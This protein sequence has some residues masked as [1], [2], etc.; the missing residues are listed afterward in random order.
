MH[1]IKIK[2]PPICTTKV[3]PFKLSNGFLLNS[4]TMC[5]YIHAYIHAH[6]GSYIRYTYVKFKHV[7]EV[8]CG[9]IL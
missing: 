5:M 2:L 1:K 7:M 4:C 3:Q 9:I 8:F 6:M